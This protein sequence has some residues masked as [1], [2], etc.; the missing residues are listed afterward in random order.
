MKFIFI[1][2]FLVK[3]IF[4]YSSTLLP[5]NFSKWLQELEP[6]ILAYGVSK[7]TYSKTLSHLKDVNKKVLKLYKIKSNL[8]DYN[9]DTLENSIDFTHSNEDFFFGH[10][11]GGMQVSRIKCLQQ[12][13]HRASTPSNVVA[14]C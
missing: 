1:N 12:R 10:I 14:C 9:T 4:F 3:V 5:S 11:F 13:L 2:I 7:Q 6:E 8:V